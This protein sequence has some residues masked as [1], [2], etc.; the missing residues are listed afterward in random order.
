[1]AANIFTTIISRY[2]CS[3]K[4]Q[5][6]TQEIAIATSILDILYKTQNSNG[7]TKRRHYY[8]GYNQK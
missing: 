5:M 8:F 6:L 1:M 7:G 3:F 2:I 4:R